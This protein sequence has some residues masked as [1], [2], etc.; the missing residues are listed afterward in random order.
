MFSL[1]W[2]NLTSD[3]FDP[4]RCINNMPQHLVSDK[5]HPLLS[6]PIMI[7]PIMKALS[8]LFRSSCTLIT[9]NIG[10]LYIRKCF[11]VIVKKTFCIK[12]PKANHYVSLYL[13][14]IKCLTY[15]PTYISSFRWKYEGKLPRLNFGESIKGF[16]WMVYYWS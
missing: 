6:C 15:L 16:E 5:G 1:N 4:Q 7:E 11:N 10:R 3:P 13:I 9:I 8:I 14:A 2:F 12:F